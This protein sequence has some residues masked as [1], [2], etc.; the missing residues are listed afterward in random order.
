MTE[1]KQC[2]NVSVRHEVRALPLTKAQQTKDS[3]GGECIRN[4]SNNLVYTKRQR[5]MY[6]NSKHETTIYVNVIPLPG[7]RTLI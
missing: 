6:A 7:F 4:L 5:D 3:G 1:R 2:A